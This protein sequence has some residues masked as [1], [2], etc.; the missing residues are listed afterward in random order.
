MDLG[1]AGKVAIVTGGSRSI[2]AATAQTLAQEGAAVVVNYV[3]HEA[4][5][6]QVVDNIHAAGGKALPYKADVSNLDEVQ[7]MAQAALGAYGQIDILVN[8]AGISTHTGGIAAFSA[9][10]LQKSV[11]INVMGPMNCIKAIS[12]H[13]KERRYG[14][15]INVVSFRG[16]ATYTPS[17]YG[18]SKTAAL[19]LTIEVARE[20]AAFNINVVSV[21]PGTVYTDMTRERWLINDEMVQQ[22][23]AKIPLKRLAQ[24]QDIANVI[25]FLASDRAGHITGTDVLVTGG[26]LF[27][28]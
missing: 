9:E 6:Q 2:G 5:A 15:I 14:K 25:C 27:H 4:A 12:P 22:V 10:H 8:N 24:P 17:P 3:S 28:W 11:A 13:M 21:S 16:Y 19:G 26:E 7:A 18:V 23:A 20:L 1:L